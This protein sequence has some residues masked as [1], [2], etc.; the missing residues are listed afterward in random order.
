MKNGEAYDYAFEHA[1]RNPDDSR[2][3]D[4]MV[5]LV[6]AQID[7]DEAQER[8]GKARRIIANRKRPGTTAPDGSVVFPGMEPY[9]YEPRRLLAD[10]EGNVV[11]NRNA[12]VK[13]KVAETRRAEHDARK[14]ME[15]LAR[16]QDES[17]YFAVWAADQLDND[18]DPH[19]VTWDTCVRETGLW[20]DADVELD[21]ADDEGEAA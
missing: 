5:E 14:A 6:A 8:R 15:R 21:E 12:R 11:E 18:R 19:E 17:G 2:V 13:F 9:S 20:K 7:F 4:D 3:E 16:E 10:D 1:K